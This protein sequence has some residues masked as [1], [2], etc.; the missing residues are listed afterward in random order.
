[1]FVGTTFVNLPDLFTFSWVFNA[2]PLEVDA[3]ERML[4]GC[5]HACL[6]SRADVSAIASADC[7]ALQFVRTAGASEPAG[8]LAS[9]R[10]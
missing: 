3:L 8:E 1:M 6:S 2:R 10:L 4:A 7:G 9:T 5:R